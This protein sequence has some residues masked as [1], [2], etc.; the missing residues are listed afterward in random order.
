MS[1]RNRHWHLISSFTI[2]ILGVAVYV[3][4]VSLAPSAQARASSM[5]HSLEYAT[6]EEVLFLPGV[7]NQSKNKSVRV[8]VGGGEGSAQEFEEATDPFEQQ[9]GIN[10]IYEGSDDFE[11]EI[12]QRVQAGNPPEVAFFPQPGLLGNLVTDTIDLNDWFSSTYLLQQYNQSWLDMAEINGQIAGVWYRTT[13]KSLVWYPKADFDAANY[14]VPTTWDQMIALSEE[15]IL[16]GRTPWCLGIASGPAT[17][18][19]GTDWVEDIMLRT[20][21]PENYDKW[22]NGELKFNSTEV[23]SAWQTMGDIWFTD[24]YVL[25]GRDAITTTSFYEAINP[26]FEDPPGCWLHRQSLFIAGFF[27]ESAEFGIDVDYFYLPP[28]DS[29]YGDP[30]LVAG[31]IAAA[32]NDT[33]EIRDYVSYLTTSESV[34][35][36]IE[37]GTYIS[38]HKD[39]KL[40]WYPDSLR[41]AAEILSDADTVRYDGSDLMPGVVGTGTFWEGVVDY[42]N[43]KDLNAIL[44][45]IDASWP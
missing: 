20:T 30:V 10:I 29:K 21:T 6:S 11:N 44:A 39:S 19:V 1:V 25:G 36:F 17:G 24:D 34:K 31:D 45:E 3:G 40:E 7:T 18:W 37:S 26:M 35:Y 5:T 4:I 2:A 9:T 22:V 12:V 38:P 41:G 32:F 33:E 8:L 43:G 27:P 16:D 23:I 14:A 42:V 13:N 28:I 15:M